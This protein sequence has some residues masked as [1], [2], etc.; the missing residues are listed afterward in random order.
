MVKN[1]E[2]PDTTVAFTEMATTVAG[3]P[4]V[5]AVTVKSRVAFG[6]KAGPPNGPFALR[7]SAIRQ[8]VSV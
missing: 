7:V 2:P 8:G 1:P 4:H 3:M 6:C 5:D